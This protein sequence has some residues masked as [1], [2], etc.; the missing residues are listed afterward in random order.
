MT[1]HLNKSRLV[2]LILYV[3]V[4]VLFI[5]KYSPR[6]GIDPV[7]SSVVYVFLIA[8]FYFILNKFTRHLKDQSFKL[9]LFIF[10]VLTIT[11]II[12]ILQIIEPLSVRVD[13]WSAVTYF[14]DSLFKGE[15][16]YAT[17][18]HVSTSNYP[19]PFPIW[20]VINLPF[21]IMGDVGYG[22]IV[23]IGIMLI[24]FYTFTKSYKSTTI[25]LALLFLSP[26]YWWEI[27]VRS[28]SLSNG[29][30][31]LCI[32]LLYHKRK[33]SIENNLYLTAI[34]SGIIASTRLSAILP[35]ALYLFPSWLKISLNKKF[36]FIVLVVGFVFLIFSP[37]IFWN[38]ES[39]IFFER[40]PFMSQ[41]SVGNPLV[42]AVMVVL[43]I[44]MAFKWKNINQ[45]LNIT[46]IFIFIFIFISQLSLILTK[47][48]SESF[49]TDS[50]LDIS[51]FSLLLPYC[52]AFLANNLSYLTPSLSDS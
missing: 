39:W 21:Y 5:L 38:T 24:T 32:I 33:L 27:A 52:I 20:Y 2:Q 46:S 25:F 42:L 8:S 50:I 14:L 3:F 35:I 12:L 36:F 45:F 9:P 48:I 17:S 30:F 6:A 29:I 13:R 47:G 26:A 41:S 40:N 49:F 31:V 7:L 23:F 43:G 11:I 51:Y 15:Y 1:G 28:D 37:F 34:I 44:F 4:N 18:T 10:T 19:S 22:L 16:P